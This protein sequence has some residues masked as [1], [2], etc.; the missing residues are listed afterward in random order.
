MNEM[1]VGTEEYV[2]KKK[3]NASA[4]INKTQVTLASGRE[5]GE[6]DWATGEQT[7]LWPVFS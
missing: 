3:K 2:F 4:I 7:Q 5:Q 6:T 1:A